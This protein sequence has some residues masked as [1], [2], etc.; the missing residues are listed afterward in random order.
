MTRITAN[1]EN[2]IYSP[3][4]IEELEKKI[5][6]LKNLIGLGISLSSNLDFDSLVES[7]LYSCIGRLIIDKIAIMLQPDIDNDNFH[8]HM[9]KGYESDEG[10]DG[11]II[12]D[13]SHLI[14]YLKNHAVPQDF[15]TLS[16]IPELK[17]D[18][19]KLK[20]L[21]PTLIVPM[22]SKNYLNGLILLGE[23]YNREKFHITEK[24]FMLDLGKFAAI[25][26]ENSRLYQMATMDRM[27]KL[28]IHHYFQER[29]LEEVK[30]SNKDNTPLC[31]IMIDIDHFKNFNDNY[32]HQQGDIVLKETAR[33]IKKQVRN[34]DI[35][36]RYGGEEFSLILPKTEQKD[37][38]L[39]ANRLRKEVETHEFPGQNL[40]LRIT[41][42][43]GIAQYNN[44]LDLTKN[45]L[46]ERADKALYK[47]KSS[48]R[49]RVVTYKE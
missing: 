47:A 41:I 31:L 25:A 40:P 44:K 6:D 22:K 43:L 26:V 14:N 37:A 39:V 28:F 35:A 18:I 9:S 20:M 12:R 49:N 36:S 34:F 3:Q 45:D 5:F 11:L 38:I 29:L 42:S 24:D 16:E 8:V 30:R 7:V 15:G 21:S 13:N 4:E 1:K 48:G 10:L 33:I 19:E 17:K 23:K 2:H 32:G 46:I 27:T